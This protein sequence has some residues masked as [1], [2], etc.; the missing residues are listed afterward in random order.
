MKKLDML[1]LFD[2]PAPLS[3]VIPQILSKHLPKDADMTDNMIKHETEVIEAFNSM[4]QDELDAIWKKVY[5][6]HFKKVSEVG[7]ALEMKIKNLSDVIWWPWIF[8]KDG[9]VLFGCAYILP[10]RRGKNKEMDCEYRVR[11][12]T[13]GQIYYPRVDDP[14]PYL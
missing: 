4:S 7:Y 1:D 6:K 12:V 8:G 13:T 10:A 14:P 3:A 5:R 2:L 11:N 9:P